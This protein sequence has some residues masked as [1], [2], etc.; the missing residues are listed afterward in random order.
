[1]KPIDFTKALYLRSCLEESSYPTLYRQRGIPYPEIAFVGRSNAG[2]SSL[3]NHLTQKKDLAYVS[4]TPGKTET[5]NFYQI[6]QRLLL[7]DLPGYG[8]AKR[9]HSIKNA[10]ET[11][12]A[13]YLQSRESLKCI[14]QIL[15]IR[16]NLS[17]EDLQFLSWAEFHKRP[18]LFIFSKAD[19]C[20]SSDRSSS[21]QRLLEEI[22]AQWTGPIQFLSYSIKESHCRIALKHLLQSYLH[23]E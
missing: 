22:R 18:L 5:L 23:T 19:T 15:D 13:H 8:F 20:T 11:H 4:N 14:V 21:E 3:L 9:S 6:D 17:E 2:K 16:R 1:M 10:W 12:L 7:V